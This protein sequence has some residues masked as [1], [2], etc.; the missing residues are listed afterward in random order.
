MHLHV[1]KSMMAW[2]QETCWVLTTFSKLLGHE[3]LFCANNSLTYHVLLFRLFLLPCMNLSPLYPHATHKIISLSQ[4][5]L[6]HKYFLE[7]LSI[8]GRLIS[9]FV[10]LFFCNFLIHIPYSDFL[11]SFLHYWFELS[12]QTVKSLKITTMSHYHFQELILFLVQDKSSINIYCIE[13][14]NN[15]CVCFNNFWNILS[16]LILIIWQ[17]GKDYHPLI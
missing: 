7:S 12:D 10:A 5:Y 3:M 15:S 16:D 2:S 13:L 6:F 17:L 9:P 11:F 4:T 1:W 8:L 14:Y